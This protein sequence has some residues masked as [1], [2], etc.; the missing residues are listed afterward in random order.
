MLETFQE[1]FEAK[2][3]KIKLNKKDI[4]DYLKT[5][6]F[7]APKIEIEGNKAIISGK[8]VQSKFSQ[9][10]GK[11]DNNDEDSTA[12][13]DEWDRIGDDGD[14]LWISFRNPE[15]NEWLGDEG[16]WD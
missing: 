5:F 12:A 16:A 15:W 7:N 2:K 9:A 13:I 8:G 11:A 1:L 6:G 3:D 4:K 10:Y 14:K